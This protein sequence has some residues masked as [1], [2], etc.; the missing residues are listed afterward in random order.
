MTP[1]YDAHRKDWHLIG[2]H[3]AEFRKNLNISAKSKQIFGKPLACLS[4]AQMGLINSFNVYNRVLT[5]NFLK[6]SLRKKGK[7]V[8]IN[9]GKKRSHYLS[10]YVFILST[11]SY[12]IYI[13]KKKTVRSKWAILHTVFATQRQIMIHKFFSHYFVFLSQ[14]FKWYDNL[15]LNILW[16]EFQHMRFKFILIP[17]KGLDTLQCLKKNSVNIPGNRKIYTIIC[18]AIGTGE[19][20]RNSS[21]FVTMETWQ[22][23]WVTRE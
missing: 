14:L 2:M 15:S 4:G 7:L 22:P 18:V 9:D 5:N 16:L 12:I 10:I 11:F 23:L 3:T 13:Y 21:S 1:R 19:F 8:A 20:L 6:K 17:R